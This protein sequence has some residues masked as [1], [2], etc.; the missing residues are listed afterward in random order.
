M[1]KPRGNIARPRRENAAQRAAAFGACLLE[2]LRLLQ[3]VALHEIHA[4]GEQQ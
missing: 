3:E 2:L 4:A 1:D